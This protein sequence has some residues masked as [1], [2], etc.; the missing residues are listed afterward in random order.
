M[1]KKHLHLKSIIRTPIY[2][3]IVVSEIG[4]FS[5]F[6]IKELAKVFFLLD[7]ID[8]E[9]DAILIDS[10]GAEFKYLSELTTLMPGFLNKK[11]SK[12]KIV[13]LFNG[14]L[15]AKELAI[16]Y[17]MK[18]LSNK[19]ISQIVGEICHQLGTKQIT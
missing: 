5:A 18:S 14:S 4:L 2:P 8:H 6:S 13:E 16:E 9:H 12:K 19:K 3:V 15:D 1:S 11:W 17:P 7:P 10:T